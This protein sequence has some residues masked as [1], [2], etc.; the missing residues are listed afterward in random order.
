MDH[1][2]PQTNTSSTRLRETYLISLA[3]LPIEDSNAP[4]VALL[5]QDKDGHRQLRSYGIDFDKED[6]V[7]TSTMPKLNF[8][9]EEVST[10]ITIPNTDQAPGGVLIWGGSEIIFEQRALPSSNGKRPRIVSNRQ[11][12]AR[13]PWP[14]SEITGSGCTRCWRM[15]SNFCPQVWICR[16]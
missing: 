8:K 1:L 6:F 3:F 9:D 16:C 5:F 12:D 13:L 7:N 10:I 11:P 4:E 15:K 2:N 14:G